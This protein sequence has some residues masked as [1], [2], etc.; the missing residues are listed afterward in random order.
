MM[1]EA[2]SQLSALFRVQVESEP[3][4]ITSSGD[5]A[6]QAPDFLYLLPLLQPFL[7]YYICCCLVTRKFGTVIESIKQS[8]RSNQKLP[9]HFTSFHIE[10]KNLS[11]LPP[12][13]HLPKLSSPT[14]VE[15]R[16][17]APPHNEEPI[18]GGSDWHSM[19][20]GEL[21]RHNTDRTDNEPTN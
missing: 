17:R 18:S 6:V 4:S 13:L 8:A 21:I 15:M 19:R 16:S 14:L 10:S 2:C 12:Q 11:Y 9:H 7:I 20:I 5:I 1:P 3:I